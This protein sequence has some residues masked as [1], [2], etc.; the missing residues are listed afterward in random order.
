MIPILL[1][2]IDN[3][4]DRR[5]IVTIYEEYRSLMLYTANKVLSDYALAEDAVSESIEKLIR[6]MHKVGEVSCYKT[7][8]FIV[9]I[10]RNTALNILKKNSRMVCSDIEEEEVADPAPGVADT[11]VDMESFDRIVA[12]IRALPD[13]Y[14]DAAVLSIVHERSHDEIAEILGISYDTAKMRVSGA[15]KMIR[16][17][18]KGGDGYA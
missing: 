12:I 8:A 5:K 10:V 7:R 11:V 18:L 14:R 1:M 17:N 16:N 2:A 9:I 3:E 6:N 15:K 13:T 4:E